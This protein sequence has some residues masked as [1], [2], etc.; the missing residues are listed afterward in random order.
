MFII[1]FKSFP[2]LTWPLCDLAPACLSP[3]TLSLFLTYAAAHTRPSIFPFL[4]HTK[5]TVILE[6]GM[7]FLSASHTWLFLDI[8]I[9]ASRSSPCLTTLPV[10]LIPSNINFW[11]STSH[12]MFFLFVYYLTRGLVHEIGSW[13]GSLGL[14]KDQGR[15]RVFQLPARTFLRSMLHPGGKHTS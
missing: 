7:F 12:S 14:A 1:N 3:H 2:W 13:V 9:L 10:S 6:P 11:Q 15:S 5:L 8:Q 4:K